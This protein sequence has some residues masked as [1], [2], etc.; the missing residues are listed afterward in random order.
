MTSTSACYVRQE[1]HSFVRFCTPF[2]TSYIP[3]V[4]LY[5]FPICFYLP[6]LSPFLSLTNGA[7]TLSCL[8]T[9]LGYCLYI[10]NAVIDSVV[11]WS[12]SSSSSSSSVATRTGVSRLASFLCFPSVWSLFSICTKRRTVHLTAGVHRYPPY[13]R[14]PSWP[15]FDSFRCEAGLAFSAV[16][17]KPHRNTNVAVVR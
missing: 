10:A 15:H 8:V 14:Q 6:V 3:S 4:L 13:T 9:S 12:V 1:S 11:I 5:S 16:F 2:N 7:T 17:K